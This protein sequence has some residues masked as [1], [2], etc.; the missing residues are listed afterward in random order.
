MVKRFVLSSDGRSAV[1][2]ISYIKKIHLPPVV[3]HI[4]KKTSPVVYFARAN[5]ANFDN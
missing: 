1:R 3:K 5:T 4:Y 2:H